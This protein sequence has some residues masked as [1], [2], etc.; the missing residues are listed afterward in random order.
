MEGVK[1]KT[2]EEIRKGVA[3]SCNNYIHIS[4]VFR[5]THMRLGEG[6]AIINA[7]INSL[8]LSHSLTLVLST[9]NKAAIA[10]WV[11]SVG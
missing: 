6:L 7:R 3:S 5:A 2:V 8:S 4:R 9:K 11:R 1:R 10:R